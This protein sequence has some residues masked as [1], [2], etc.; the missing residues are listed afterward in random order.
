MRELVERMVR[1]SGRRVDLC[2]SFVDAT[3]PAPGCT[4]S[5]PDISRT[6]W[7]V[8]IRKFVVKADH[9]DDLIS[10]GTLTEQSPAFPDAAVKTAQ[11]ARG[12]LNAGRGAG[13]FPRQPPACPRVSGR[14]SRVGV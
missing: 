1:T 12:R 3:L 10:L 9:L 7:Q 11:C 13:H 14:A 5:S 2:I 6:Y 8:N 4:S